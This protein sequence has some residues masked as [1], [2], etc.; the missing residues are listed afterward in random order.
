MSLRLD[1]FDVTLAPGEPAALLRTSGDSKEAG[2]WTLWS[3]A[4]GPG[5]AGAVAVEG[6]VRAPELHSWGLERQ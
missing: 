4:P 2:R 3:L 6:K 1:S 5:Y